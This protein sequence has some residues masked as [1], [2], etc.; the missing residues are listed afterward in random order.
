[1]VSNGAEG[2]WEE[3]ELFG[4]RVCHGR[5]SCKL[6]LVVIQKPGFV[7]RHAAFAVQYGSLDRTFRSPRG[8]ELITVAVCRRRAPS[9]RYDDALGDLWSTKPVNAS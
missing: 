8:G 3:S 1:M 2:R 5:L 7:R 4:E 6:P 9:L